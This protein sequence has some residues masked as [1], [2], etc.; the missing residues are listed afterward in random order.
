MVR[1]MNTS[2]PEKLKTDEGSVLVLVVIL[3][4]IACMSFATMYRTMMNYTV[5]NRRAHQHDRSFFMADAALA[6]A[7]IDLRNGGDGAITKSE[8]HTFF[9][10]PLEADGDWGFETTVSGGGSTVREISATG[11]DGSSSSTVQS[12]AAQNVSFQTIHSLYAF[13][14]YSGNSSGDTN[15]VLEVGGTG[16]GAD[17]VDGDVYSGNNI[18]VTGDA[19]LRYPELHTDVNGDGYWNDGEEWTEFCATHFSNALTQAAYDAYVASRSGGMSYG[20]GVYDEGEAFVDTLGNGIFDSGESYSDD[21][22]DGVY[23]FGDTFVD[24]DGDG[25]YDA[26]EGFTDR[27]NGSYDEGEEY[28]DL[29]GNGVWDAASGGYY[30]YVRFYFWTRKVWV[31]GTEE[32]PYEDVGNGVYDPGE[33]FT[34]TD[35]VYTEGEEFYD[36][37][38][39]KY[40]YGTL[41]TGE[42]SGMPSPAD[43][44]P[45]VTGGDMAISPPDLVNMNYDVSKTDSTPSGALD[46]WGN[47]IDVA[48]GSYNSYGK[49]LDR[50][51]PRH[52]FRKNPTDRSY[53][54]ISGKD[55]Y[56]LE[57]PTDASYGNSH[58]YISVEENGNNKVYYV[59]GNLYIHNGSTYDF[60]FRDPGVSITIV[61]NG[62]ITLS[63]EFW[64]NGGTDNPQDMLVLIAMKD[65]AVADSGNIYLGDAQFGTGGDIHAMLYAENDFVDNNLDTSGQPYLSVF[66]NMSAGNQVR[67]NR[68]DSGTRTRLDVTLDERINDG[69]LL[70]PGLPGAA[71]GERSLSV[72]DEWGLASGTWS[73]HSAL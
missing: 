21:D 28:Q 11:W 12:E 63:D 42:V 50:D 71:Y 55:D 49:L 69:D 56:F 18:E 39:G 58:Q 16:S 6:A 46:G 8:S 52:I 38:N 31:E 32:E 67:I 53:S 2:D 26:G 14:I 3:T 29:N 65:P 13:A 10:I 60:M 73:S 36:D 20:N 51:D 66:G 5:T 15:Y 22:G 1:K 17:F 30:E 54:K 40:D 48:A 47:D 59:D 7:I 23:S 4:A 35:G 24:E 45:E 57:D 44:Y 64:Y 33:S 61:A 70:P 9:S 68:S 37:Q 72:A 27:G 25:V 19:S 43:G 62:N 41:A 34:D